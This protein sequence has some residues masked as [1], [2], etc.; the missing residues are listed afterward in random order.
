MVPIEDR[1]KRTR[2]LCI[3]NWDYWR[4]AL[5]IQLREPESEISKNLVAGNE[6]NKIIGDVLF[7]SN[8]LY[9]IYF[10][11]LRDEKFKDSVDVPI[12]LSAS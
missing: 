2:Y 3:A 1:R 11:I 10:D 9:S 7:K 4:F 5:T 12:S 6:C 8:L